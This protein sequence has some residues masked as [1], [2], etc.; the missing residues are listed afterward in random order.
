MSD[1]VSIKELFE[2]SKGASLAYN[3]LILLPGHTDF[4]V[5]DINLNTKLSRNIELKI[6]IVS[7]P[8]DTVTGD[9]LA[10]WMALLGGIGFIHYNNTIEEQCEMVKAVKGYE[11]G[12]IN[13]PF[14]KKPENLIGEL[15]DC[16]YSNIPIT[17]DGA[18]H[19]KLAGLLTKYDFAFERHSDI[20]IRERMIELNELKVARLDQVAT[21]GNLDLSKANNLLFESYSSALPIV[22]EKGGLEYLVTRKD[23]ETNVEYPLATKDS[24]K[25]LRVGAAVGTRELD[26]ERA[27]ALVMAGVDAIKI[28]CAHGHTSYQIEMINYIKKTYPGVDIASGNV[29]TSNAAEDL[30]KAGAD[31]I[32]VGMGIGS[33]CITQEVTAAGRAQ[34]SAI[35]HVS[36][37]AK[38]YN[39]PVIADGGISQSGHILK[40]WILGAHSCMAGNMLA[41]T[42]E[43]LGEWIVTKSG[44][45]LK[46]Y[47]GMGSYEAMKAGSDRR[48]SVNMNKEKA[49]EGV[50]ASVLSKGHVYDLLPTITAGIKQ[51]MLKIGCKNIDEIRQKA[52][53]GEIRV[54][55]RTFSAQKEGDVH[56]LIL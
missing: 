40:A 30:I 50:V 7:A 47:R 18:S 54:E 33:M 28:D 11:N 20:P 13:E 43:S 19:G 24:H 52:E 46:R 38:K 37:A 55:K 1:G 5:E 51:G 45:K 14:V 6:P 53:K 35:Y 26:K 4:G 2:I 49:A 41:G 16:P 34:A 23:I 29:V 48:Y 17:E 31:A 25:K 3:D 44:E 27:R 8:M 9:E 56:D 15:K 21:N 32:C 39:I 22:D 36:Q 12:F 42:D 10:R